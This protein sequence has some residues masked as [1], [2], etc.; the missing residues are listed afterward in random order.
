MSVYQNK[1]R[2]TYYIKV[3]V[4]GR[5]FYCYCTGN[6]KVDT[7]FKFLDSLI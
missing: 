3:C 6:L 4:G 1:K 5:Y 2:G 7:P